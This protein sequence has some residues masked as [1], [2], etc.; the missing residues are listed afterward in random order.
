VVDDV[1]A[2]AVSWR[3]NFSSFA[4]LSS[5]ASLWLSTKIDA[6][7]LAISADSSAGRSP[8]LWEAK[9]VMEPV[10]RLSSMRTC[11]RSASITATIPRR[12]RSSG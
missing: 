10:R 2:Q 3:R 4:A 6:S 11:F 1:L 8:A 9:M 12:S 5:S 7:V